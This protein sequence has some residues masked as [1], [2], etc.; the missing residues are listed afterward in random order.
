MILFLD[1]LGLILAYRD[2]NEKPYLQLGWASAATC[3]VLAIVLGD[4]SW[5]WEIMESV[6][7]FLCIVAVVTWLLASSRK[8]LCAYVFAMYVSFAPQAIDYYK[9]P[10]AE[11]WWLWAGTIVACILAIHGAPR[12]DFANTFV[13]FAAVLL[14]SIILL[15]CLS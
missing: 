6:S 1:F 10:Q 13:P 2:G 9:Q 3:V 7:L 12:R 5:H 4:S 14:N 15:L 8:A 11:T